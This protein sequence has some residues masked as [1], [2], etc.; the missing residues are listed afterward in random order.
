MNRFEEELRRALRDSQ[1]PQGFAARVLARVSKPSRPSWRWLPRVAIVVVSA[2]VLL[3]A[4]LRYNQRQQEIV[5]AERAKQQVLQA[6]RITRDKLQPLQDR[7]RG[8]SD[9]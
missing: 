2:C 6:L 1:P 4:V 7:L 9:R 3:V 5:Q 8:P